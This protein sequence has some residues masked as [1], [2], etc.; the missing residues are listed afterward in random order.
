MKLSADKEY[1][2]DIIGYNYRMTNICAAIGLAQMERLNVFLSKKRQLAKIYLDNLDNSKFTFQ[3]ELVNT[4]HSY[5]M[6]SILVNSLNEREH[7]RKYLNVKGIETRPL[8]Y[9][10]Y[11]MPMY[12]MNYS[13]N[14][15]PI[16]NNL[17]MRGINI[18]SFP[19]LSDSEINYIIETLNNWNIYG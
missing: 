9:P 13:E 18:P 12:N 7:L 8:F 2:H 14:L 16:A 6:F 15:F 19:S 11:K 3:S 10:I 4:N 1:W 5:W 17:S